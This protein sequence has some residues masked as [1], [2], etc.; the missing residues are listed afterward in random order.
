[1][2][3]FPHRSPLRRVAFAG[4]ILVFAL[5]VAGPGAFAEP[6]GEPPDSDQ[7]DSEQA[8]SLQPDSAPAE[9]QNSVSA[10]DNAE[11]EKTT[12]VRLVRDEDD[13]LHPDRVV[14]EYPPEL[15]AV[16]VASPEHIAA[17]VAYQ[18]TAAELT[19]A[20][21]IA[22][23]AAETLLDLRGQVRDARAERADAL[24]RIEAA[25]DL[26]VD[27]DAGVGDILAAR[28]IRTAAGS[29]LSALEQLTTTS[30][31]DQVG[32]IIMTGIATDEL[33]E[34]QDEQVRLAEAARNDATAAD[35]AMVALEAEIADVVARRDAAEANTTR[36]FGQLAA[37]QELYTE[38]RRAGLVPGTDLTFQTLAAYYHAAE[39]APCETDWRLLA[40]IGWIESRHGTY[41]NTELDPTGRSRELI[42][43]IPLNGDRDTLVI[44]DS[45]GGR[46]DGDR[47]FDRA[48]GPMQFIPTTWS[49]S[50]LD[51]NGDT[52]A[53]PHNLWD[54]A[55]SAAGYLC[56]NG[57][58]EAALIN[59]NRSEV[60]G[61][62]V[63]RRRVD[64]GLVPTPDFDPDR[65]PVPAQPTELP[66]VPDLTDY[67]WTPE[68][69]EASE[70]T[71]GVEGEGDGGVEGEGGA[72]GEDGATDAAGHDPNNAAPSNPATP[73][74]AGSPETAGAPQVQAAGQ[75]GAEQ[76]RPSD[77]TGLL[78][79]EPPPRTTTL[80][81]PGQGASEAQGDGNAQDS[82]EEFPQA[83]DGPD[84][85]SAEPD[86]A[87]LPVD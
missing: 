29:D 35:E 33:L 3:D 71:E 10:I 58:G 12:N 87:N 26:L 47:R 49:F 43:G 18:A 20:I 66:V 59:Y 46:L 39:N 36:L 23:T 60:Y 2:T 54:A 55:A 63:R 17:A 32:G 45:D 80:K 42:I 83:P 31:G 41:P 40:G 70:P 86:S 84:P 82:S 8:E 38:T 14:P 28:Y 30:T 11:G 65:A 24:E 85:A 48:I 67:A 4:L 34:R 73:L 51:G 50:G 7:P 56:R 22:R 21:N 37:D 69:W 53:D 13:G 74:A 44:E 27:L 61:E 68:A 1:M 62:K 75:A 25:E 16:R 15:A 77:A 19:D 78:D 72:E 6:A 52:V 81:V 57:G 9:R 64:Y 76:P 79:D 5:L